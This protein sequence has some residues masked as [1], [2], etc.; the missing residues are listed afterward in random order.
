MQNYPNILT[1]NNDEIGKE[2]ETMR[3]M[4][5]EALEKKKVEHNEIREELKKG[6]M[7]SI[8]HH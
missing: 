5:T 7:F 6:H 2:M 4:F 3:V 1:K 8:Y